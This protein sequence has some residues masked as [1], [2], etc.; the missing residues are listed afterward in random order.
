M[1]FTVVYDACVLYPFHIRDILIRVAQTGLVHA[2]WTDAIL[3][4]CFENLAANRPD[5]ADRLPRTRELMNSA[6]RDVLVEGYE[7]LIA[8]LELPHDNDRHVLAAAI[9]AGAQV[10]VTTN[11]RHFP[12]DKIEPIEAQDPDTFIF[13]LIDLSAEA[14]AEAIVSME[15]DL[16]SRPGLDYV[17]KALASSGLARSVKALKPFFTQD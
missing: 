11:L 13:N 17:L 4:E 16:R 12:P 7:P 1:P 3:D 6:I 8:G 2:R 15:A 14:V 10:I 5:I 9:K